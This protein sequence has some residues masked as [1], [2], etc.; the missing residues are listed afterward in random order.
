MTLHAD[1][2]MEEDGLRIIDVGNALLTGRIMRRQPIDDG[3]NGSDV[4]RGRSADDSEDIVAVVKSGP[5][6][7]LVI[8][9]VYADQA[10]DR[11][12]HYPKMQ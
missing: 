11:S 12:R 10:R 5:T 9:T 6:D 2:E 1:D 3:A 8:F 4:V 7:L